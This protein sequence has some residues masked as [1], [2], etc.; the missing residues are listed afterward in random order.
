MAEWVEMLFGGPSCLNE[1][2]NMSHSL[3][4]VLYF[5]QKTIHIPVQHSDDAASSE[6]TLGFLVNAAI[7]RY[8]TT[9]NVHVACLQRCL[10]IFST[11]LKYP[12]II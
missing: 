2:L 10:S 11:Q 5:S 3:C 7:E 12:Y 9:E 8:V 1:R 6:I 4:T